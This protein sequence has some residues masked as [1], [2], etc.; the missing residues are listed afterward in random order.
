[1]QEIETIELNIPATHKY[2]NVV[3]A[4]LA[5]VMTRIDDL[6]EAAILTYNVQLAVHEICTNIVEHAYQNTATNR[7]AM[8]ISLAAQPQRLVV[9]LR[10]TGRAFDLA[11][12]QTPT[13]D[14][15]QEGGYGLFLVRELMDEVSYDPQPGNNRWRLTKYVRQGPEV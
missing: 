3:G 5:E 12:V 13:L 9:E 14:N 11:A 1:M 4:C 6:P 8:T 10:D 15:P 7:I 2:L